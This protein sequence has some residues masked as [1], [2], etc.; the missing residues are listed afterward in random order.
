MICVEA[1]LFGE[2]SLRCGEAQIRSENNRARKCWLFLEYLVTYHKREV[3]QDELVA[4]LW[5]D[6]AVE[7]PANSLKGIAYRARKVLEGLHL[8]EDTSFFQVSHGR[9]SINPEIELKTDFERFDALINAK[10]ARTE[11]APEGSREAAAAAVQRTGELK[12]AFGLYRDDFLVRDATELWVLPLSTYYHSRYLAAVKEAVE[13]WKA[14]GNWQEVLDICKKAATYD[15]YEEFLHYHIIYALIRLNDRKA[16]LQHYEY[17]TNMFNQEF[18]TALSEQFQRLYR[19]IIKATPRGS[20]IALQNLQEAVEIDSTDNG[21]Y[22][23]EYEIFKDLY[24]VFRRS[25]GR[26]V[27]A[28]SLCLFSVTGAHGRMLPQ[29]QLARLMD[30]L[31][32]TILVSLRRG[33][34]VAKSSPTQFLTM[35]PD[36]SPENV[37]KI[38]ARILDLF[39]ANR[40]NAAAKVDYKLLKE[41]TI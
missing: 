24:R 20:D 39:Y 11:T 32:K 10:D 6:E 28:I 22:Y 7:D 9:C 34:V 35:L 13:L 30:K 40:V 15:R 3:S 36:A 25:A 27:R 2:F 38:A 14:E 17:V 18:G 23:C 41:L 12:E 33:D 31:Q 21:A 16:A 19:E 4:A 5:P 8:P 1:D 29:K 37:D 26:N